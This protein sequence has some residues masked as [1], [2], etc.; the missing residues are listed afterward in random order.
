VSGVSGTALAGALRAADE[1]PVRTAAVAVVG[2]D[3]PL[4]SH[5]PTDQVLPLA[6]VTKP[7]AALAVLVAVEEGAVDLDAPAGPPGSTMRH[8]LAHSSGLIFDGA[9]SPRRVIARPGRTRIYSNAGFEVMGEYLEAATGIPFGEYFAQAVCRP[10][11]L[12]GTAL[13]GS[14]AFAATSTVTD[15]VVVARELLDPTLV[16]P[17]TLAEATAVQFPGLPGVLPGFGRQDPNDW[18]LGFELRDGKSPHWT[19]S[20]NSPGT[21]GHFGRSGTFLWVDPKARLAA[22]AL[23]DRDFGPWAAQAWPRFADGVLAAVAG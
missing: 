19:G 18:G 6:S 21:F 13:H 4:G 16:H 9:P 20:R 7:L 15:L 11:R 2:P 14:P 3:G 5:G 12:R 23:T 22:V 10:L 17:S 1:W 8:L